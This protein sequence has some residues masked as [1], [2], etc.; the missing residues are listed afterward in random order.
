VGDAQSDMPPEL[1]AT[2]WLITLFSRNLTHELVFALWDFLIVYNHPSLVH[3]VLLA[4]VL[5]HR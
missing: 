2:P 1:Y 4:L 3:C 5:N